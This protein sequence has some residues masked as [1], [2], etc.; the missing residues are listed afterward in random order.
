MAFKQLHTVISDIIASKRKTGN[1]TTYIDN[2]DG[3]FTY[4]SPNSFTIPCHITIDNQDVPIIRADA[5]S[6]TLEIET[7]ETTWSENKPYFMHEKELKAFQILTEKNSQQTY[8]YQKYPLVLLSH[9]FKRNDSK[10]GAYSC[11][12]RLIIVNN[13]SYEWYSDERYDNNFD[14]IL[15]PILDNILDGMCESANVVVANKRKIKREFVDN[16]Y[17]AGNPLPDELDAII[18]EF[19]EI[20]IANDPIDVAV[21]FT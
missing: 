18:V 14:S 8:K 15:N 3:T 2:G 5:A 1:I 17:I 13:T 7:I 9:P 19:K 16:L 10:I 20:I 12:F 21:L 11:D 4:Y 6:F